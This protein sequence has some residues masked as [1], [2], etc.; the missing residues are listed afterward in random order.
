M[1]K[2]WVSFSTEVKSVT[3]PTYMRLPHLFNNDFYLY[4]KS[5]FY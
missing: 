1:M 3:A 4:K 2:F 5:E